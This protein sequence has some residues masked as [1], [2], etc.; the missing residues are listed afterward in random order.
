YVIETGPVNENLPEITIDVPKMFDLGEGWTL[1]SYYGYA[2]NRVPHHPFIFD[3][4]GDIRWYGDFRSDPVLDKLNYNDGMERLQ[5]GNFYFGFAE[6]RE[7]EAEHADKIYEMNMLGEIINIWEMPG[8]TFHHEVHEKPNGNFVVTVDKIGEPT[9]EDYI[10]EIDRNS[11][12]IINEWNLN[13]SLDNTRRVLT[14]D[15]ED[16][17][18]ANAVLYDDRDNTI[19]VSGRTQGVVKLTEQ[20][21]VVWIMG[22]GKSWG[23]NEAGV[24]L[25][26]LVLNPLDAEGDLIADQDVWGGS[27]NHE[28]FE[29]NWYQHAPMIM[30]NGNILLFDNGDNRNFKGTGPY[31]RAVEFKVDE[32]ALTIQQ[33][34]EYGKERGEETYSRIV[35]DVD[36]LEEDKSVIFS[37]GAI[38]FG[39]RYGKIV[40]IDYNSGNVVFEAT[41]TPPNGFVTFHRTERLSL[42]PDQN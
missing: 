23:E 20:N 12:E 29:W 8:Y 6:P 26:S 11:G 42:Y 9:V 27:D 22:P 33:V 7:V 5:N 25:G 34:W 3:S 17:F 21:E 4:F 13:E 32:E 38:D 19:I 18:H 2:E 16:W 40:E 10:I 36:Y 14:D 15:E 28:D 31:S 41:I 39:K 37:P 1:V 30:P 35:S 24:D